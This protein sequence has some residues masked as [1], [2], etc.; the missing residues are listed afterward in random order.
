M[1]EFLNDWT[2]PFLAQFPASD[3]LLND[4]ERGKARLDTFT[5]NNFFSDGIHPDRHG[6]YKLYQHLLPKLS[7]D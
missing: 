1:C 6:H 2:S 4:I 3:E 7:N 5:K